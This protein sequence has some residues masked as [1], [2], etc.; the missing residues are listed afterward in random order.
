MEGEH[1][2]CGVL[3]RQVRELV[4]KYSVSSSM[5]QMPFVCMSMLLSV[6]VHVGQYRIGSSDGLCDSF[7]SRKNLLQTRLT[8]PH[9]YSI[10]H[11]LF[12]SK[13]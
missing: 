4:Y 12:M 5:M 11:M 1:H 8:H 13:E 6:S 7:C 10:I 3:H 2:G 9:E